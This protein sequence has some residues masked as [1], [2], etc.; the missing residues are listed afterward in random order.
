MQT[1]YTLPAEYEGLV[2]KLK[3]SNTRLKFSE[4][5]IVDA[6]SERAQHME[7][8]SAY[9]HPHLGWGEWTMED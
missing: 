1:G 9:Y 6:N 2:E 5:V 7:D 3:E 4:I 8:I